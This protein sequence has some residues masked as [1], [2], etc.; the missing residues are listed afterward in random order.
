MKLKE[1]IEIL[2]TYPGDTDI[3]VSVYNDGDSNL[4]PPE[5]E[6]QD[7]FN[8]LIIHPNFF[9]ENEPY[10]LSEYDRE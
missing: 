3:V 4:Y 7:Y 1:W 8:R 9:E 6:Y 10:Y 2:K 5:L